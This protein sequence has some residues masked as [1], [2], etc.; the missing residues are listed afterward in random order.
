MD[1]QLKLGGW[2]DVE[3]INADGS[4][5]W[6]ERI[7]NGTTKV[8][9]DDALAVQLGGGTQKTT[10]YLGLIDDAGFSGLAA[11]DTMASHS[12]WSESTAY[13]ESVRPTWSPGA[14]SGQIISNSG[15]PATF[16]ANANVTI[17]GAF[18]VSNSTKG[19]IT[20]TLWATGTFSVTQVLVSGQALKVTYTCTASGT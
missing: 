13:S 18:L 20:G 14:V 12:G 11:T 17:R 8:G 7:K 9:L 19:G 4:V 1:G 10:W 2:F 15:A 16:T 6:R 3:C 5:A